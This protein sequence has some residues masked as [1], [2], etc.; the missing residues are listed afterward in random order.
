MHGGVGV[1]LWADPGVE[2]CGAISHREGRNSDPVFPDWWATAAKG[3]W[4][5][6]TGW[7]AF[8]RP[9]LSRSRC[10]LDRVIAGAL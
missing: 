5:P 7:G 2:E 1:S 10:R 6:I 4:P 8:P 3:V 9:A